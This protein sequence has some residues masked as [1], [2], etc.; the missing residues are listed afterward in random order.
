[1]V[2]PLPNTSPTFLS[3]LINCTCYW[4][5]VVRFSLRFLV[6][7]RSI[8]WQP[9]HTSLEF[10]PYIPKES[11]PFHPDWV[12]IMKTCIFHITAGP[13]IIEVRVSKA[14]RKIHAYLLTP[15]CV[16]AVAATAVICQGESCHCQTPTLLLLPI[17]D[18]KP[19][20][21]KCHPFCVGKRRGSKLASPAGYLFLHLHIRA[22][23][24]RRS[25][26]ALFQVNYKTPASE[27]EEW[28]LLIRVGDA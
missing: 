16:A 9:N 12:G 20:Y 18:N 1:M 15:D 26:S 24:R 3:T 5:H 13:C 22:A 6:C 8:P 11:F 25:V 7:D 10:N 4:C 2:V 21:T 23:V 19:H 27:K 17:V 14:L 28:V